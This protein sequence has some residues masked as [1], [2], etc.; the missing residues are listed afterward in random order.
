MWTYPHIFSTGSAARPANIRVMI[1]GCCLIWIALPLLAGFALT[2]RYQDW[3]AVIP[4]IGGF[5]GAP[6]EF[7]AVHQHDEWARVYP[8]GPPEPSQVWPFC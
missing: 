1:I 3:P 5:L 2:R 6:D 8:D 4:V 7:V